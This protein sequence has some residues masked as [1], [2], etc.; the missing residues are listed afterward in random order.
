MDI[1]LIR[2]T[3]VATDRIRKV[4]ERQPTEP[5]DGP[6]VRAMQYVLDHPGW[7]F[8][9]EYRYDPGTPGS[10]SDQERTRVLLEA[11]RGRSQQT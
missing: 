2:E 10:E 4:F 8:V 9:I 1:D 5:Y 6:W 3:H 7:T 11:R